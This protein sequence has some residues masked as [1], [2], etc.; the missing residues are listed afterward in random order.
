MDAVM[1]VAKEH[2]RVRR[3]PAPD[4]YVLTAAPDPKWRVDPGKRCRHALGWGKPAC[5]RESAA[6]MLR[7]SRTP[8][9][10]RWWAYCVAH[11]YGRW[12]EDGQVMTWILTEQETRD[13]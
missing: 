6:A 9:A 10:S 12:V 13:G 3:G 4:G 1:A 8:G 5:G 7:G 11:M 2:A